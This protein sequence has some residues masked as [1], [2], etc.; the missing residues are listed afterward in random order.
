MRSALLAT[1]VAAALDV[2]RYRDGGPAVQQQLQNLVVVP[3]GAG[4][5]AAVAV[6][7]L[8]VGG[9]DERGDVPREVGGT[10]LHRLPAVRLPLHVVV[11]L[12]LQ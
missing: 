11:L 6:Q 10:G 2:V 8:P 1:H 7:C 12:V 4:T 5:V 9:Q 3:G